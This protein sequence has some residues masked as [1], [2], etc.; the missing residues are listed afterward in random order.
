MLTHVAT[1]GVRL[2]SNDPFVRCPLSGEFRAIIYP[3][4]QECR[5]LD[6]GASSP[7]LAGNI[8]SYAAPVGGE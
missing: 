7:H 8:N 5:G 2:R 4:A 3:Y 1:P 6:L